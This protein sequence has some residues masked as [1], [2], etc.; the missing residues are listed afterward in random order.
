MLTFKAG[1]GNIFRH[2]KVEGPLL[3]LERIVIKVHMYF[4]SAGSENRYA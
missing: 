4:L 2:E 3:T 1:C